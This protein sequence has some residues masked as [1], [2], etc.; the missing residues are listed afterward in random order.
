MAAMRSALVILAYVALVLLAYAL[1]SSWVWVPVAFA[2]SLAMAAALG[3]TR[4]PT[5]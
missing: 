5:A 4:R 3:R 1:L 2:L